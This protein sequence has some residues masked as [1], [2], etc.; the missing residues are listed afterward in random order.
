MLV[1]VSSRKMLGGGLMAFTFLNE[2]AGGTWIVDAP[3]GVTVTPTTDSTGVATAL[4]ISIDYNYADFTNPQ[5]GSI[6]GINFLGPVTNPAGQAQPG[7]TYPGLRIPTTIEVKNDLGVPINGYSFFETNLGLSSSNFPQDFNNP[8]PDDYAHFHGLIPTSLIDKA[9]GTPNATLTLLDP[10]FQPAAFGQAGAEPGVPAPNFISASGTILPGATEELVGNSTGGTFTVHSEDTPGPTGGSFVLA[11]YPQDTIGTPKAPPV[12][13]PP[14]VTTVDAKDYIFAGA[15]QSASDLPVLQ[16]LDNSKTTVNSFTVGG[17]FPTPKEYGEVAQGAGSYVD[18]TS[19]LTVNNGVLTVAQQA[20]AQLVLD[21][22]SLIENGG[23][24][25][26][27]SPGG[28]G[29]VTVNGTV[30]V[31]AIGSNT[32]DLEGV[33]ATG[34]GAVIQRG[35]ND[36]THVSKVNDLQFQIDGGALVIDNALP[37]DGTIGPAPGDPNTQAIGIFGLVEVLGPALSTSA[38]TFDTSSGVLSL[39]DG[40][41][42]YL[43]GLRFSGDAS[44]LTLAVTSGLPSNYLS[45]TDHPGGSGGS[46]PIVFT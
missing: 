2:G 15:S 41:G 22:S 40:G 13:L 1:C 35:E 16:F 38:A 32:L 27:T 44:G 6:L 11:F 14:G 26:G 17:A 28:Q 7:Q 33:Q 25:I 20:G 3:A 24:L 12:K 21:G 45:I 5:N 23:T 8:H 39:F 4:H 42:Q 18:V 10:N 9:T 46:I 19:G 31:A 34:S 29:T 43:G 30:T 36:I 37:F